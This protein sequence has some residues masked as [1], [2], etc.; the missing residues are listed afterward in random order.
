MKTKHVG[1]IS[2][3]M[4]ILGLVGYVFAFWYVIL[5]HSG[6]YLLINYSFGLA[7]SALMFYYWLKYK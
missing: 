6:I 4:L 2:P 3:S 7:C 5:G 1:D